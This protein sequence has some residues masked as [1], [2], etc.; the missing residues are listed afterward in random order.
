MRGSGQSSLF[1]DF[2]LYASWL[3]RFLSSDESV[4]ESWMD[5][6]LSPYTK[7]GPHA[8]KSRRVRYSRN[9]NLVHHN[10]NPENILVKCDGFGCERL[11]LSLLNE[12]VCIAIVS[13]FGKKKWGVWRV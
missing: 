4:T 7:C 9:K 6:S 2:Y 11:L 8:S 10:L 1:G 3:I 12:H 5:C 13:G